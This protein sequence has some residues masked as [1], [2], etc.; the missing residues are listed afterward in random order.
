MFIL[1]NKTPPPAWLRSSAIAGLMA[2]ALAV[3]LASQALADNN[4]HEDN[5]NH[6]GQ[7]RH[8]PPGHDHGG[9]WPQDQRYYR[10]PPVV[11][12]PPPVYYGQPPG[13]SLNFLFPL[14]R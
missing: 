1:P 14:Y 4:D 12:A 10:Q 8:Q 13:M 5:G 7:M 11:Y 3:P 2:L 9:Y 6:R